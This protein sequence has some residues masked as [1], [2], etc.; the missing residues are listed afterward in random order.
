MYEYRAAVREALRGVTVLV[1]PTTMAPAALIGDAGATVDVDG[2]TLPVSFA[3]A[4]MTSRFNMAG[5]PALSL[6]CGFSAAGLPIGMSIVGRPF[7]EWSVF[8][9]AH[10]YERATDWHTRRPAI[11]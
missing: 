10:A 5:T 9:V 2:T 8:K 11:G 3:M 1:V 7:D 4:S 6:P